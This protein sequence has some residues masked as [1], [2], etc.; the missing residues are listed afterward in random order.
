MKREKVQ[1]KAI[2]SVGY[3]PETKTLEVEFEAL[4]VY[5]YF[6]VSEFTFRALLLASSKQAFFTASINGEYKCQEVRDDK[7]ISFS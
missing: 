4:T 7:P 5:Q 6:E 3:D 2:R 1:S